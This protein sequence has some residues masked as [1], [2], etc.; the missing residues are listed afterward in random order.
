MSGLVG[1]AL[2]DSKSTVQAQSGRNFLDPNFVSINNTDLPTRFARTSIAQRRLVSVFG[3]AQLAYN[4]YAFLTVTGR[5]DWTSTIP[6]ER[7]SFFYPSV[8]GSFVVS[9]AVESIG[10]F[11]TAKIRASYAEVGRDARPYAFR[12]SL[13]SKTTT[14]GGYGYGFTG[15][16]LGLKPEFA[17]SREG[18]VELSWFKDRLSLDATMYRK[19]T[20][21]QIV[22]DIRGSYGTGFILFNLNGAKTRNQGV[23][24]VAR[25][26]PLRGKDKS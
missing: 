4:D 23:E 25:G 10:R 7:N 1:H 14:G 22:N 21:D 13:E 26:F 6:I 12:P 24:I 17:K 3:Q 11:M 20:E 18:G 16:N 9:D 5:N 19:E 15:P 2:S 8:S